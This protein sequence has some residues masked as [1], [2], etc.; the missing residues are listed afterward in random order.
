MF[1]EYFSGIYKNRFILISLVNRDLIQKYRRS[2]LGI[3]WSIITPLGLAIIIGTIYSLLFNTEPKI[4]IPLLFAG[5]NPWN[6]LAGCADSGTSAFISAEGYIKQSTVSSQ[7]F[8][9]RT[10]LTNM[11]NLLYSILTFFA[12]YLFL[13]PDLFSVKM[14]M[15]IP[16][17]IIIF[18]FSWGIANLTSIIT[19]SLRD[20]QPLQSLI[21]QGLFYITP[22][23]YPVEMLREKGSNIIVDINPFYYLLEVVRTPMLGK[24]LPSLNIYLIAISISIG[25]FLFSITIYMKIKNTIS[26]KL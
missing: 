15:V 16:G 18:I 25:V 7:I 10:V 8:P 3:A 9:L 21:L 24:E 6:F 12:I 2:I 26:Y 13:E 1:R 11:I 19:L 17:L 5:I 14:L 4:L 20:F 22:I 23:I